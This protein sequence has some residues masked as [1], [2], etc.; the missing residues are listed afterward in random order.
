MPGSLL[1]AGEAVGTKEKV[2]L[3]LSVVGDKSQ[4]PNKHRERHE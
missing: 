1:G 3:P 4:Q 2:S